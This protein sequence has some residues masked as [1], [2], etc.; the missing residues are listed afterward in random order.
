MTGAA[1]HF[2]KELIVIACCPP[3]K[4]AKKFCQPVDDTIYFAGEGYYE[5]S[6]S[7][8]VEAALDSARK[9]VEKIQK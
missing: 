9:V 4:R 2:R 6:S 3:A 8:T 7:A 1:I 5:G